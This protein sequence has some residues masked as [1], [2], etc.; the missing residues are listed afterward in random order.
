MEIHRTRNL[1]KSDCFFLNHSII[2]KRT[3]RDGP[4]P[5]NASSNR[6][7]SPPFDRAPLHLDRAN[8]V[9]ACPIQSSVWYWCW[10]NRQLE[11]KN[12]TPSLHHRQIDR[13]LLINSA[14]Q[15]SAN[16]RAKV[17]FPTPGRPRRRKHVGFDWRNFW[18]A[19]RRRRR[20]KD[21]GWSLNVIAH[22]FFIVWIILKDVHWRIF[23]CF[24]FIGFGTG[25][26]TNEGWTRREN[27]C[28]STPMECLVGSPYWNAESCRL[29][30]FCNVVCDGEFRLSLIK[31]KA[32]GWNWLW[33]EWYCSKYTSAI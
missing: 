27:A 8:L 17:V 7:F 29:E 19:W 6:A 11:E 20:G 26:K 15:S 33:M 21:L 12:K 23:R 14:C 18:S 9:H 4:L 5:L 31:S 24:L 10:S 3:N 13:L 25:L 22:F 1:N 16:F 2:A 28:F 30:K 32:L